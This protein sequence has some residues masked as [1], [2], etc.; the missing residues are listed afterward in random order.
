MMII[1]LRDHS[2]AG[3]RTFTARLRAALA[4]IV[5]M[6]TALLCTGSA[7]VNAKAANLL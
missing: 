7:Y 6:F 2:Q 5:L 4:V 1:L 3:V